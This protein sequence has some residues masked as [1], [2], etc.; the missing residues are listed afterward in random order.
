MAAAVAM[1][2]ASFPASAATVSNKGGIV[3]VSKGEGFV[4]LTGDVELAPGSRVMV[5]AEGLATITYASGCTVHVGS[6]FWQVRET[7]P[8]PK[9]T[10]EID[11]TGRMN[12]QAPPPMS[13]DQQLVAG[14]VVIGG[15]VLLSC[16]VWWCRDSDGR[17]ASP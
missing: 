17:P 14:A 2:I 9:D 7:S 1:A 15:G 3:L 16:L 11:F 5:K 4:P 13:A 6:G 8:C 12:Q 10:S